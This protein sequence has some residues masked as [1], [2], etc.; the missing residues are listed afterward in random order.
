MS[1]ARPLPTNRAWVKW[2]LVNI[3]RFDAKGRL[4]EEFAHRLSEFSAAT[5][6]RGPIATPVTLQGRKPGL[7]WVMDDELEKHLA[8]IEN[9]VAEILDAVRSLNSAQFAS[10]EIN[11]RLR[12]FLEKK[13]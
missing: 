9:T 11:A 7:G 5:R 8:R 4:I 6:S 10:D 1:P 3:F 12:R 13:K 2:D